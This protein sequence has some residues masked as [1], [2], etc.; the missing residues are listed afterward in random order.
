MYHRLM[1][2][3][4]LVLAA[5]SANA[6]LIGDTVNCSENFLN[7]AC[8]PSSAVVGAGVEFRLDRFGTDWLEID[9]MDSTIE[10]NVV[11]NIAFVNG[12]F[13][14][15][16]LDWVD[17]PGFITGATVSGNI[18]GLDNSRLIVGPDSVAVLWENVQWI[19]GRTATITL[20]VAH[21][22]EPT[23]LSLLAVGLLGFAGFCRS[24]RK[25]A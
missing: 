5:S 6:T 9:V 24:K 18:T 2:A 8:S 14:L 3:V 10:L 20:D 1:P 11:D 16:D 23:L 25:A 7:V 19:T 12:R 15:S 13:T 21:V 17:A 22:P 4:F